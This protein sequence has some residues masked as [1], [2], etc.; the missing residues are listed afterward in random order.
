MNILC[1]P[2]LKIFA[3]EKYHRRLG[4]CLNRDGGL[5]HSREDRDFPDKINRLVLLDHIDISVLK[6]IDDPVLAFDDQAER[7][8][9]VILLVDDRPRRIDADC[10]PL[11]QLV[12]HISDIFFQ[13]RDLPDQI[14]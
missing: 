1:N 12:R 13:L 14:F 11:P 7:R 2:V 6:F 8:K 3:G 9:P 5:F 10:I 4:Q